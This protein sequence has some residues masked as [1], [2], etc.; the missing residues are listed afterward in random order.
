MGHQ[1]SQI[2]LLIVGIILFLFGLVYLKRGKLM[3]YHESFIGKTHDELP[4]KLRIMVSHCIRAIGGMLLGQGIAVVIIVFKILPLYHLI[5]KNIIIALCLPGLIPLLF[6]A[7]VVGHKIPKF[8]I[9][10]VLALLAV[11]YII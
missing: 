4:D 6:T 5:G 10:I 2:L 7:I 1:I 11:A 9:I 8:S 3:P